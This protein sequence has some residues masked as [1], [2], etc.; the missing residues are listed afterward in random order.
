MPNGK[1]D[2]RNLN[3]VSKLIDNIKIIIFYL[4]LGIV[5][6]T[7]IYNQISGIWLTGFFFIIYFVLDYFFF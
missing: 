6:N 7:F 1:I 5:G 2:Y 3:I 4:I